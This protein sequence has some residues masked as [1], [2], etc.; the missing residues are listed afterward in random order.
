MLSRGF[1]LEWIEHRSLITPLQT[2]CS[3]QVSMIAELLESTCM[4]C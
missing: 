1:Q 4:T 3:V 2:V